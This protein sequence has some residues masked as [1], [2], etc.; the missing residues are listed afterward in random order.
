MKNKSKQLC[1]RV[2]ALLCAALM[3]LGAV[4]SD[5][6]TIA[7]RA[8]DTPLRT[9]WDFG[10]DESLRGPDNGVAFQGRSETVFGLL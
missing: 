10:T 8:E 9:I 1:R 4:F 2:T 5:V 6:G 7:I 3:V